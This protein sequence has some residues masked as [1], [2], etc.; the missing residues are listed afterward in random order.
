MRFGLRSTG[1]PGHLES[2][3]RESG[4]S[5]SPEMRFISECKRSKLPEVKSALFSPA[6]TV[7]DCFKFRHKIGMDVA[8]EVLRRPL[9]AKKSLYERAFRGG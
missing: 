3:R 8:L 7:A 4:S 9:S 2:R 5:D 1:K 6:K